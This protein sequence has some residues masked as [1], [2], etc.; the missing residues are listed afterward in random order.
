MH[1]TPE[2]LI[3][4]AEAAPRSEAERRALSDVEGHI[5]RCASCRQQVDD[6]R[7]MLTAASKVEAPE[8]SPL[9]WD[10][11]SARVRE[12]VA[13]EASPAGWNWWTRA[14]LP[15]LAATAVAIAIAFVMVTRLIAPHAEPPATAAFKAAPPPS[16]AS[17]GE[18]LAPEVTDPSLALVADL[19]QDLGWDET[20]EAGLAP[21]GS[22]D[23]AVT[24]LSEGELRELR[25]LLQQEI[26]RS[27]SD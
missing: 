9:F 10:H 22:A 17:A 2:Q 3:D 15:F 12:A 16:A 8:P 21:R 20:R 23:H 24:H 25:D 1:L 19:T 27:S 6:I 26:G 4:I 11:L 18:T 14:A 7:A 13:A 5:A